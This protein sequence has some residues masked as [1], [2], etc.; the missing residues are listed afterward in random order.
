MDLLNG[1]IMSYFIYARI[2]ND[3]QSQLPVVSFVSCAKDKSL[4]DSNHVVLQ[5]VEDHAEAH[6]VKWCIRF[7]RTIKDNPALDNPL[8]ECFKNSRKLRLMLNEE[9]YRQLCAEQNADFLE[10]HSKNL[11]VF[12]G[13]IARARKEKASGRTTFAVEE[14]LTGVRWGKTKTEKTDQF[15]IND[16]W[17]PWY[18]RAIQMECPDL[19]GFFKMRACV[20]D[21][22]TWIDGR[23]WSLFASGNADKLQWSEPFEESPDSD[24]EYSE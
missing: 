3:S 24:R 4:I 8:A 18:S 19:V 5:V 20:A 17:T 1:G 15:K 23:T 21:G 14:C 13:A 16:K 22:M 10:Y 6:W 2:E 11:D 7:R 9:E 12:K